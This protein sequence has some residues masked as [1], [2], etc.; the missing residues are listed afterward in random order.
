MNSLHVQTYKQIGL[1]KKSAKALTCFLS[2]EYDLKFDSTEAQHAIQDITAFVLGYATWKELNSAIQ[3][4]KKSATQVPLSLCDEQC[5]SDTELTERR[6]FQEQRFLSGL[7]FL[8][9]YVPE[10]VFLQLESQADWIIKQ[11]QPSAATRYAS[12][13][14]SVN[15]KKY[16]DN[17]L[18][19]QGYVLSAHLVKIIRHGQDIIVKDKHIQQLIEAADV[20]S[21]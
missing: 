2:E 11:W 12:A 4:V 9:Q 16:A 19:M 8:Q 7:H 13:F 6:L 17:Q 20:F 3:S 15:R 1:P 14:L 10:D 18:H 21:E 5:T